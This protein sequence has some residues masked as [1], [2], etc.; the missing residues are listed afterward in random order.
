MLSTTRCLIIRLYLRN[1][2]K[3]ANHTERTCNINAVEEHADIQDAVENQGR[4]VFLQH[5]TLANS[6]ITICCS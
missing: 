2:K 1:N 4:K 3:L 5:S 6:D